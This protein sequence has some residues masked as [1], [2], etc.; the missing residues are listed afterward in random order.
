MQKQFNNNQKDNIKSQDNSKLEDNKEV[1]K[2]KKKS[3][4][5]LS[6]RYNRIWKYKQDANMIK[7]FKMTIFFSM[8]FMIIGFV[9]S[10]V[11]YPAFMIISVGVFMYIGLLISSILSG[12]I[13]G[14][15]KFIDIH[16]GFFVGVLFSL[17]I[18]SS[19][20]L[21]GTLS[22]L[23]FVSFILTILSCIVLSVLI[24]YIFSQTGVKIKN[25]LESSIYI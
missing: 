5:N 22:I 7:S 13:Y 16:S 9:Y 8:I 14:D 21:F 3:W 6:R 11:P 4:Y 10:F 12:F 25:K 18:T 19:Y 2:L 15:D 24:S 20:I 17:Y 23:S 1:N